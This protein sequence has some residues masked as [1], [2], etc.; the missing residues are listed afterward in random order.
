MI[1]KQKK[2]ETGCDPDKTLA[3]HIFRIQIQVILYFIRIAL[4][5]VDYILAAIVPID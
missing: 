5:L 4:H 1:E 2:T 3:I